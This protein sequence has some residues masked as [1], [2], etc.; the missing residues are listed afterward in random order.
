MAGLG[1]MALYR[2]SDLLMDRRDTIED[3]LFEQACSL[4]DF[5][6]TIALHGLTNT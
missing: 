5:K 4:F 2:A 1:D 3:H 6:P